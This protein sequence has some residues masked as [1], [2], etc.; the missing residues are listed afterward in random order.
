MRGR[1]APHSLSWF[2][3]VETEREQILKSHVYMCVYVRA[4]SIGKV[5]VIGKYNKNSFDFKE[6]PQNRIEY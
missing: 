1:Y 2:E 3:T 4:R 6:K 5:M